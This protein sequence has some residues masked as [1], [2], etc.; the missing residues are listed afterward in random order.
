MCL[1]QKQKWRFF[2]ALS[3][4]SCSHG[5]FGL[6]SNILQVKE[7]YSPVRSRGNVFPLPFNPF[8]STLNLGTRQVLTL[9]SVSVFMSVCCLPSSSS[10]S[11]QSVHPTPSSNSTCKARLID[12]TLREGGREKGYVRWCGERGNETTTKFMAALAASLSHL[13]SFS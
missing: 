2:G 11:Y 12:Q 10:S 1:I 6:S 7:K 4:T 3:H 9:N 13:Y 8:F 5:Y